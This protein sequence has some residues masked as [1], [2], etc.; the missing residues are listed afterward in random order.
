MPDLPVEL[1]THVLSFASAEVVSA[2]EQTNKA[3]HTLIR[4]NDTTIWKTQVENEVRR[5]LIKKLVYNSRGEV[6]GKMT[7]DCPQKYVQRMTLMNG[8]TWKGLLRLWKL[9]GLSDLPMRTSPD[10]F[11]ASP[12]TTVVVNPLPDYDEGIALIHPFQRGM[13][14]VKENTKQLESDAPRKL[15]KTLHSRFKSDTDLHRNISRCSNGDSSQSLVIRSV[16]VARIGRGTMSLPA[17][18]P[19]TADNKK[20]KYIKTIEKHTEKQ[21]VWFDNGGTFTRCLDLT[22]W[23]TPTAPKKNNPIGIITPLRP[24]GISISLI[25]QVRSDLLILAEE[26]LDT[27]FVTLR[28]WDPRLHPQGPWLR[29]IDSERTSVCDYSGRK[30]TRGIWI[31]PFQLRG[32]VLCGRTLVCRTTAT[33]IVPTGHAYG[34]SCWQ[35]EDVD[36]TIPQQDDSIS[37][38]QNDLQSTAVPSPSS[39]ISPIVS[40]VEDIESE[41]RQ[42][43]LGCPMSLMWEKQ[44]NNEIIQEL[45]LNENILAIKAIV[46]NSDIQHVWLWRSTDGSE[47]ADLSND[48]PGSFSRG[49]GIFQMSLTRFHIILYNW[50]ILAVFDVLLCGRVNEFIEF[51]C[52]GIKSPNLTRKNSL[53]GPNDNKFPFTGLRSVNKLPYVGRPIRIDISD[54]SSIVVLAPIHQSNVS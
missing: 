27:P 25:P 1:L 13:M 22:S 49:S 20:R 6:I 44:T 15:S 36:E 8:E 9:W 43:I 34:V 33:Q 45:A 38:F 51:D 32:A 7:W 31:L 21:Q 24:H 54:D 10:A 16:K 11:G 26:V 47:F 29:S 17:L 12:I 35:L 39:S 41:P 5:K 14:S 23:G 3:W 46:P 30:R 4:T 19:D 28:V 53:N 40:T 50:D 2:F 48:L 42:H 52:R 18:F 37:Y